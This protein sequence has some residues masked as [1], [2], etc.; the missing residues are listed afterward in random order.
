MSSSSHGPAVK[1]V[2]QQIM[3][4][5]LATMAELDAELTQE[6]P[7]IEQYC[8]RINQNLRQFP[9]M[10]HLLTDEQAAPYYKAMVKKAELVLQPLKAKK[11]K[12][13]K[14][15]PPDDIDDLFGF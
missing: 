6:S 15:A 12:T 14:V 13:L 11:A 7:Q 8:V 4:Q 5:V 2:T 9:D 1:E 10:I 3:D